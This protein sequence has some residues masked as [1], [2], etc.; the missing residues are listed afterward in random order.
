[1]SAAQKGRIMEQ[2]VGATLTFQSNGALRVSVP[3][4]DDESVHLVIGNRHNDKTLLLQIKSRFK[5]SGRGRYRTNV[6]P[7]QTNSSSSCTVTIERGA[8]AILV[9]W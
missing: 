1:M 4:I 8:S 5:L 6:R 7:M 9:G 3:L 2:L